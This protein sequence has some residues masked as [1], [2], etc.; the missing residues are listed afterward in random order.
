MLAAVRQNGRA[1]QLALPSA[2]GDREIA[3]TAVEG[4]AFA[5]KFVAPALQE[6]PSFLRAAAAKNKAIL[7]Y[8]RDPAL[9]R[10]AEGQTEA[11]EGGLGH[12]RGTGAG[13]G[14]GAFGGH[15][16][17]GGHRSGG[18]YGGGVE[19]HNTRGDHRPGPYT[20]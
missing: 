13:S 20:R 12:S 11:R 8:V 1:L 15:G 2:R 14:T 19:R 16:G 5:L 6:D 9:R 18:A 17:G 7:N 10:H 4:C 3:L